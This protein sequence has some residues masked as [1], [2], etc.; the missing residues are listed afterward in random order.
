MMIERAR[1]IVNEALSLMERKNKDYSNNTG[2]N[3]VITGLPGMVTRLTDKVSRLR[4]LI[5]N[6]EVNFE[7][8]QDT[9]QD[10]LNYSIIAKMIEEGSW[11]KSCMIYLAGPIDGVD[12]DTANSWR[13]NII[14]LLTKAGY[15]TFNPVTP[16]K[17]GSYDLHYK[18]QVMEIDKAAIRA[19]DI[20]IANLNSS[21]R[22]FGT[23]REIEYAKTLNK[24]VIIVCDNLTSVFA[25]DLEVVPNFTEVL[26]LL[27]Q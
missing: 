7:S 20:L 1:Q 23:V 14:S 5:N 17:C 24:R 11:G 8:V 10:I 16:Y 25:A 15:N 13:I 26:K 12:D 4:N 18:E 9:L 19:C 21:G 3:L 6:Q 2:N 22:A 27:G